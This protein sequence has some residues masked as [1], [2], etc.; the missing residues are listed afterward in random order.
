MYA[1]K[2]FEGELLDRIVETITADKD[3]WVAIMMTEEHRLSEID[4]RSSL[5]SAG[6]VGMA[7][8]VGSLLPLAPFVFLPARSGAWLAAVLAAATL[9]ALGAYKAKVTVGSPLRSGLELAAIGSASAL[10]GYGVGEWLG[11]GPIP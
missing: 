1:G 6:V 3:V 7:T 9:F 10:V 11:V 2:G 5:R 8:L 4:H